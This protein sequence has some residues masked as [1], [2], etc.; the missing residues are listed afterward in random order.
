[1]DKHK[2]AI[3]NGE[4]KISGMA[5]H[6]WNEKGEHFPIWDKV[7]IIDRES[8]WKL[9]KIKVAAHINLSAEC[10]SPKSQ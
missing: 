10:I 1:M 6:I 9:R 7:K 5:F 2:K 8:S 3:I 4:L